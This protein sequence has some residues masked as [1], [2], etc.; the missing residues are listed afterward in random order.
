MTKTTQS[1]LTLVVRLTFSAATI[2]GCGCD[3]LNPVQIRSC[4]VRDAGRGEI[5]FSAM[6]RN[7]GDKTAERIYVLAGAKDKNVF[8]YLITGPLPPHQWRDEHMLKNASEDRQAD[9]ASHL[10]TIEECYVHLV[11]YTDGT[12]W[13]GGTPL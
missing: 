1:V 8:E 10:G 2:A 13:D 11:Y 6:I 7:N 12:A 3:A 5:E 9:F 4:I